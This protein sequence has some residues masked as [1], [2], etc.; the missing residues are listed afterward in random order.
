MLNIKDLKVNL[1]HK[2]WEA[3]NIVIL[4]HNEADFDAIASAVSL[5]LITK[6]LNQPSCIVYDACHDNMPDA[7]AQIMIDES[8]DIYNILKRE[9]FLNLEHK[10][11][12]YVLTD[13]NQ[14]YRVA[15]PEFLDK[16]DKIVV[17]DHHRE[18]RDTVDADYKFISK[19][20]S[21][22]SE[23][24][25]QLLEEFDIEIPQSV[26]NYLLAGIYLD[27]HKLTNN[28]TDY[29]YDACAKLKASGAD[30]DA[31]SDFFREDFVSDRKVQNLVSNLVSLKHDIAIMAAAENAFFTPQELAKAADYAMNFKPDASFA[32]GK[33]DENTVSVSARGKNTINVGKIMEKLGGGGHFSSGG[34]K[35]KNTSVEDVGNELR[36]VLT[37][38]RMS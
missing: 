10:N 2:I 17:I 16:P 25:T 28:I 35:I 36:K 23:I 11:E 14:R 37:Y 13:V 34:A 33:I 31:V 29:V 4:P 19:K 26:A 15:I 38:S 30:I 8:Q 32:I 27:T 9:E 12:L 3:E 1:E 22:A 6:K 21:S 18:N 7:G 20:F 24:M 5:S